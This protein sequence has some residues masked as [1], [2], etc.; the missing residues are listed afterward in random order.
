[1]IKIVDIQLGS[2]HFHIFCLLAFIG[3]SFTKNF[4]IMV[5]ADYILVKCMHSDAIRTSRL[6]ILR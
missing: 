4:Y 3:N 5:Y 2:F 1:M 6:T